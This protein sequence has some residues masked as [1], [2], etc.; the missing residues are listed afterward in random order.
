M[1]GVRSERVVGL[2]LEQLEYLVAVADCQA[3]SKA[4]NSLHTSQQN[5]SRAIKQLEEE[6]GVEIF[7]RTKKGVVLTEEGETL[8]EQAVEILQKLRCFGQDS[9]SQQKV[10]DSSI[11]GQLTVVCPTGY[12]RTVYNVVR[13]LNQRY[14]NIIV[15]IREVNTG[16]LTNQTIANHEAEIIYT[17]M[18]K[19]NI[20]PEQAFYKNYHVYQLYE[21]TL[22][23]VGAKNSAISDYKTISKKKFAELPIVV[24]Y[25]DSEEE[26][27]ILNILYAHGLSPK[28]VVKVNSKAYGWGYLKEG[29][30]YGLA[31]SYF[32]DCCAHL[33]AQE[34]QIVPLSE[35]ITLVYYLLVRQTEPLSQA[36]KLYMD[37]FTE[38]YADTYTLVNE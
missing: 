19:A 20:H 14:P 13:T 4:G 28:M 38:L 37:I 5:I 23:I 27:K 9:F 3:I 6:L 18:D 12:Y 1:K 26:P 24:N 30:A 22:K 32:L 29:M 36:A 33:S 7:K 11:K 25:T 35:K 16:K 8:Y 17:Y 31:T 34:L 2:K 15:S 10:V 21:E